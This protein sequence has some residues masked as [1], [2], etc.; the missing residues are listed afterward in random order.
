MTGGQTQAQE[1]ILGGHN[2]FRYGKNKQKVEKYETYGGHTQHKAD[3]Y[4]R[5]KVDK[6]E[7]NMDK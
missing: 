6:K 3:N 4:Q 5:S 1:S 7:L 2:Q